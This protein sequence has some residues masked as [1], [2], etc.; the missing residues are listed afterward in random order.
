[1]IAYFLLAEPVVYKELGGGYTTGSIRNRPP[2]G[3]FL[4]RLERLGRQVTLGPRLPY[5]PL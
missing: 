2:A 3:P 1:M 5:L 4:H